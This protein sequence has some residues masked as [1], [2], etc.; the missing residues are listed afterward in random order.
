MYL[1]DEAVRNRI[2]EKIRS[3]PLNPDDPLVIEIKVKTRSMEQ[4]DKFHAMLGDISKQAT[5]QGDKYDLYGW[6]NLIVS[7]HTIATKLPYKLV[8]GIEGELVNVREQTSRMGVKRMSS[9]IEYTTA[10]G[11]SNG[12]RF[13]DRYGFWGK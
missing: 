3:L 6:K 4:N 1:V 12:V 2:I 13:N 8:T 5:W 7:G 10:W 9:L 11:V